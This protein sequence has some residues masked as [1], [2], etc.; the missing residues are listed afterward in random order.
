MLTGYGIKFFDL[1]FFRHGFLVFG[2]GVKVPIAFTGNEF[3]FIAHCSVPLSCD[4]VFTHIRQNNVY[5]FFVNDSHPFGRNPQAH[6]AVF[7]FYPKP[8]MLQ[9]GKKTSLGSIVGV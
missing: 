1:H 2:G 4:A 9:V 8:M 7:A 3:N 6:P 5:T